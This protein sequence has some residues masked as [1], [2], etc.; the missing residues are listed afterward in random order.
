[1]IQIFLPNNY[2]CELRVEFIIRVSSKC[3]FKSEFE[4]AICLFI[5]QQSNLLANYFSAAFHF[6]KKNIFFYSLA[7]S[8]SNPQANF[9]SSYLLPLTSIPIFSP[10]SFQRLSRYF[11]VFH[12]LSNYCQIGKQNLS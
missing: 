8:K 11:F 12:L 5:S 4:F 7:L 2:E 6:L 10:Y 9:T 1:M 3:M